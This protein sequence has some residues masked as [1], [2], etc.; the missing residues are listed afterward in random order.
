ANEAQ[1]D[2][3]ELAGRKL[4]SRVS[5]PEAVA[6]ARYDGEARDLRVAHQMVDLGALRVRCAEVTP[7]EGSVRV[8]GPGLLGETA[9][10][11]LRVGAL[12]ERS[13][14]VA[15][16]FP[17]RRGA[18]ELGLEPRLLLRPEDRLRRRAPLRVFDMRSVEPD[19]RRRIAAVETTAAVE[20]LH[21][22]LGKH[23]GEL[24]AAELF[25]RRI[26]EGVR[27][28]I[29]MLVGDDE[30]EMPAVAQRPVGL[31]AVDGRQVVRLQPQPVAIEL[32]DRSVFYRWWIEALERPVPRSDAC[33]EI[34]EPGLIRRDLDALARL[35]E[36]PRLDD[37][38]PALPR[39]FV[40]VPH[41]DE[42][43]AR[44]RVLEV[45]I[46]EIAFVDGAVAID[47]QR[48]V[49]VADLVAIRDARD[50]VDRA[51]VACLHLVG[52]FDHL[53]DEI[54]EVQN[55]TELLGG[56]SAFIFVDH[57]AIG[58]ELAFIDILTAHEREAHR[59]GIVWQR[60]RDR[61]ADTA[62]VSVA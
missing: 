58:V 1:A 12:I 41:R 34:F 55:E 14:R 61:A 43:P 54:A 26:A 21:G 39:E 59:A 22:R 50:L 40:V 24:V 19:V 8:R 6:V 56:G 28:P 49:E 4:R 35:L 53:V 38:L 33:G 44:A 18:L 45:G 25:Q 30:V 15:P 10:Q 17:R 27:A 46:G 3:I 11:V 31:E 57:S 16:D 7:A 42:Q 2:R 51:V 13:E 62:A 5:R 20:S 37:A 23:T 52:I 36:R 60:R 29:A 9:G 47:G 32:F 48:D